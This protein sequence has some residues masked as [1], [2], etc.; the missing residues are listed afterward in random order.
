[1]LHVVCYTIW[2]SPQWQKMD[3][4]FDAAVYDTCTCFFDIFSFFSLLFE[5]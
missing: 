5:G 2:L 4:Y 1:M 3:R